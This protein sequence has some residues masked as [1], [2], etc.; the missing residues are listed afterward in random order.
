MLDGLDL[1]ATALAAS[2][3]ILAAVTVCVLVD[4]FFPPIPSESVIIAVAA[5]SASAQGPN[6]WLLVLAAAVG[7]F[8]GDLLAYAMGATLPLRRDRK[9]VV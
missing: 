9:S 1:W 5:L 8:A 4:A 6:L 7:A 2:P 3:W